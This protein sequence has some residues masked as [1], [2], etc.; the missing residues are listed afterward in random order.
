MTIFHHT[1]LFRRALSHYTTHYC[2]K[3]CP[4][5]TNAFSTTF[6][7]NLCVLFCTN[8]ICRNIRHAV[9]VLKEDKEKHGDG[10]DATDVQTEK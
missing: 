8:M 7:V 9:E 2:T 3:K 1:I 6:K 5:D 10:T 4:E